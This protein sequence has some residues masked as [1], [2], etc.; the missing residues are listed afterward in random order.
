[1]LASLTGKNIPVKKCTS[2]PVTDLNTLRIQMLNWV[3]RFGIFCFLDNLHY[4]FSIPA[5]EC[6][7]AAGSKR[8]IVANAGNAFDQLRDFYSQEKGNWLFGHFGYDLKNETEGL[9]SHHED[10][11][12][13]NDLHFFEP[14]WVLELND[15]E[16]KIYGEGDAGVV[17]SEIISCPATTRDGKH[18]KMI[19]Q[20]K[21]GKEDYISIIQK[22]QQHILNLASKNV[23]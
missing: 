15:R 4:N 20:H 8:N 3:N 5:F 22:L 16:M 6:L 12:G 9:Y 7:V 2:F 11:V 17:Y 1:M 10:R 14:E 21:I 19:L 23:Q 18:G 13:F